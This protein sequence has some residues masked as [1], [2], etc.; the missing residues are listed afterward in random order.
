MN[1]L[2]GKVILVTGASGGIGA[3]TVRLLGEQGA[4]VIA[5]YSS[6]SAGVDA[7]T[8]EIPDERRH[9][10]Q[11][12]FAEAGS[13]DRLWSEAVEWQGHVDALVSNAAVMPSAGLDAGDE[14][15]LD[16]WE[17]ALNIN[18]VQAS[19][20]M[21]HAARHFAARGSGSL[22]TMSSW[23]AQR[24]SGN[25]ELI[26]YAASKAAITAA[27]K[28][29]ARAYALDGVLA[30]C[31]APGPVATDMT[32]RSQDMQGGEDAVLAGLAMKELIPPR[33]I[34]EL[35]AFLCQGNARHLSGATLDVNGATYIR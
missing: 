27:T 31:I 22:I 32:R 17:Q 19:S 21:R 9:I 13:P 2:S 25:R 18:V 24:G 7:A 26:A 35:V 28:T 12:N 16:S 8:E 4:S 20:L 30:Y 29:I 10:L 5:Q 34:A 33:E 6:N 3:E 11:A 23:A 1:D 15:W 14:A